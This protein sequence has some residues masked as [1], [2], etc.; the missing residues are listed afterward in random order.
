MTDEQVNKVLGEG[1]PIAAVLLVR[2]GWLSSK[3]GV[4]VQVAF[5]ADEKSP[6][7]WKVLLSD[8]HSVY[9]E[10]SSIL[11]I[12]V[13]RYRDLHEERAMADQALVGAPGQGPG[14]SDEGE[15]GAEAVTG[16]A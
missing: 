16:A 5:A 9:V 11:G 13:E 2:G 7:L 4:E 10:A 1:L 12:S 8:S 14:Q 15:G 3:E 6:A